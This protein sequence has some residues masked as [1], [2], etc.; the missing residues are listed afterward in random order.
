VKNII[1]IVAILILL[2]LNFTKS[3]ATVSDSLFATIGNK[4]LTKFDILKE[5]KLILITNGQSFSEDRRAQLETAAVNSAIKNTIKKIEIE[6]YKD[7][8]YKKEDLNN[9]LIRIASNL[10]MDVDLLRSTLL[11]NEIEFSYLK[12]QIQTEL[13][14]NSLI[15][16]IYKDRISINIDEVDEQLKLIQNA[17]EIYEY[18][19]S[20]IIIEPVSEDKFENKISEIKE[21]IKSE[22]FEQIAIDLSIS[23]TSLKGGD[24]G[25]VNENVLSKN[26]KSKIIMTKLGEISE[27]IILPNGILFFKVRDKRKIEKFSNLEEAK[28]QLVNSQKRKILNMYSLTHYDSLKRSI[29]IEYY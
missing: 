15:F 17:K 6:K 26:F 9:E 18:L 22:G 27:P 8:T 20:E 7:L 10:N 11:A 13:L 24:L 28:N 2:C 19:I 12:E 14:W 23:E 4:A 5:L 29:S 21:K 1:K 25:W 16:E 3:Q